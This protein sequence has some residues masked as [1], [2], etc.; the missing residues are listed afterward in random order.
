MKLTLDSSFVN[1]ITREP[2]FNY[3]LI[4][5]LR[6]DVLS[7]NPDSFIP[8]LTNRYFMS[9]YGPRFK[10]VSSSNIGFYDFH[11]GQDIN[12]LLNYNGT[13]YDENNLPPGI[14]A[15]TGVV[16]E[17]IDG[18]DSLMEKLGTGRSLRVKCNEEFAV[19]GWGNI[20]LAYRHLGSIAPHWQL[21]D[22]I[23]QNDTV[24]IIGESGH[25]ETNH[26]HYSVQKR[27]DGKTENV[28]TMR[29]FN[30]AAAPHLFRKMNKSL[31]VY[32]LGYW[33]D[34]ALFR[35]VIPQNMLA[36]KRITLVYDTLF[37]R[38][39]DIEEVA[40]LDE[41]V[42]DDND[43]IPG[44]RYFAYPLNHFQT[45]YAR[46]EDKKGDFPVVYP[47]SPARGNGNFYAIPQEG[48]FLTP[49]FVMEILALDLPANYDITKV[50]IKVLS[51]HGQE[52][53]AS[54]QV[55]NEAPEVNITSPMMGA[56]VQGNAGIQVTANAS[57]LDGNVT[58]VEFYLNGIKAG[59]DLIAPYQ[60][61][62]IPGNYGVH[63]IEVRAIDNQGKVSSDFLQVSTYHSLIQ[64]AISNG[65]DDVE[66]FGNGDIAKTNGDLELGY[67]GVDRGFQTVGL[68]FN[69]LNVPQNA[70]ITHAYLQF[71]ADETD[72]DYSRVNIRVHDMDSA[73]EFTYTDFNVSGR[74]T[75][76]D[77]VVW[78]IPAWNTVQA[79]T[80]NERSP[81]IKSLVQAIVNRNN[82]DEDNSISF[83]I[84]GIGTRTAYSFNGTTNTDLHPVLWVE[85]TPSLSNLA[86]EITVTSPSAAGDYAQE[87]N[88][89]A[90]ASDPDGSIS[91]V[92]IYV[93]GNLVSTKYSAPYSFLYSGTL[94]AHEVE[95]I[96]RDNDGAETSSGLVAFS[97]YHFKKDISISQG[98]DDV[99][100][101]QSGSVAKFNSD[102]E[103]AY[104]GPTRGLQT[105]GLRF[106]DLNI[107]QGATIT[108]AYIQFVADENN[109]EVCG[110]SIYVNDLDHAP[111]FSYATSNVSNRAKYATSVEWVPGAWTANAA[112]L[113][114]RTPDLSVLVQAI[115]NRQNWSAANS[116][117]FVIQGSGTRTAVS[118]D[119]NSS[120]APVL[121][122]EYFHEGSQINTVLHQ[123]TGSL[124][125]KELLVYPN[126]SH[127]NEIQISWE[128]DAEEESEI[129]VMSLDGKLVWSEKTENNHLSIPA[130]D[131]A[132]G[133]YI[134][135]LKSGANLQRT[136]LIVN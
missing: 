121:H 64:V 58:R 94:G 112:G 42:R 20:L 107:P 3:N 96:A 79:H 135:W 119:G 56:S 117:S 110:L 123:E 26:L 89:A 9:M 22:S 66:E 30:P 17:I 74:S 81:E 132:P 80:Y 71:A 83:A 60:F 8:T 4:D 131:I 87:V 15:C 113:N 54:G 120:A 105:V 126:P 90:N 101:Y 86:P 35:L 44:M 19:A 95:F 34:S 45:A 104:D 43:V 24:G 97:L 99:E 46:Y 11:I 65:N 12:P 27:V 116:M 61:T 59:E 93:D 39:Y 18:P 32:Q 125:S 55:Y 85:Y 1:F 38:V 73:S 40:E 14:C 29:V 128:Q 78:E 33:Q 130:G 100:E 67:D 103:M 48:L 13:T 10:Q 28:H 50:K 25:T 70:S 76:S 108:R 41:S 118:Y 75:L 102:L 129:Q 111:E 7:A 88:L 92:R 84:Q 21:G 106:N 114:Q 57:D 63:E 98:K 31:E 52:F 2:D 133:A 36:T 62:L 37:E 115:I 134:V 53:T 82:W 124:G 51:I 72:D 136:K 16:D 122:I 109:S 47:A 127:G 5:P 49:A 68:R 6:A 91:E 69:Q 77:S 23:F